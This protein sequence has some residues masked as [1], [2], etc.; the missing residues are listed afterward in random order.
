[1]HVQRGPGR[2]ASPPPTR[3]EVE[4]VLRLYAEQ[5]VGVVRTARRARQELDIS[6]GRVYR[7]MRENGMVS[8][9]AARSGQRKWVRYERMYSN[10]LWHVDWH[11][12]KDPRFRGLK[13]VTF[14]D[15]SSRCVTAARLFT[16]A[17]SE[18]AVAVLAEAVGRFGTPATV[19]SDNGRCFNGGRSKKNLPRGSWSPT[20]FEAA[21]LDR[22]IE[23]INSGPYHPET[24]GKLERFHGS[25]ETEIH[26]YGSLS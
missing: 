5:D 18:N 10:T 23:M 15:D 9:S 19:L 13:L 22:G 24:N 26:H 14:L 12:M 6:Y 3:G 2:R 17:T 1:V 16:E 4:A 11:V 21:L 25:I 20:A 8:P 7:I